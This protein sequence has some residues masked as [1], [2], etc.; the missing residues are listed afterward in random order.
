MWLHLPP[1][2]STPSPSAPEGPDSTLPSNWRFLALEQSAWWRGS[3][4]PWRLW[5]RRC[6][7][8]IWL[9]A[10]SGQMPRPFEA[11]R[12]VERWISLLPDIHASH[13]P[14]PAVGVGSMTPDTSGPISAEPSSRSGRDTSSL[15]TSPDTSRSAS[16]SS[17]ENFADLVS[18][19]RL[20]SSRRQKQAGRTSASASSSSPSTTDAGGGSAWPT[21]R[22]SENENRTTKAAPSHGK[23][24]GR[25]LA[26][27]ACDTTA[28]QGWARPTPATRDY[29]GANGPDHLENGTGRL[30]LDQLPNFVAH[31]WST[32]RASDGEKGGPNQSFGGGGV[33]LPAQAVG[34]WGTPSVADGRTSRSGDRKDELLLNSLAAKVSTDSLGSNWATPRSEMARAL[35]NLKHITPKRAAGNIE[36]QVLTLRPPVPETAPHG[37]GSPSTDPTSSRL[38]LNPRFVEWLM[39]WPPGWTSFGCSVMEFTLWKE[40]M[41]S[42]LWRLPWR[43]E[44]VP[45]QLSLFD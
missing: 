23:T 35:G 14:S 26:G 1:E 2:V 25:V 18:R 4:S 28:A 33:P 32:P 42:A 34:M 38:S 6:D 22:S 36:D 29:K 19:L 10:L 5:S 16:T 11:A 8:V 21:P 9:S 45:A 31:S 15:R 17:I 7:K 40:R 44:E 39:C 27:E 24:H 12:G 20:A 37:D 13:F 43:A 30:H 3:P 41:V